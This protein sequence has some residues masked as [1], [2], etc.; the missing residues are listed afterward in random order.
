[1]LPRPLLAS[2]LEWIGLAALCAV[3]VFSGVT[4][5]TDPGAAHAEV[6]AFGLEGAALVVAATVMVQLAGSAAIL[7]G[8]GIVRASGALALLAFTV[9]A[10][11]IGHAFWHE[12]G[13]ARARDLNVFLE[14]IGLAGAF[15]L[16]AVRSLTHR[17]RATPPWR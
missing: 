9:A 2:T 4:K 7:F 1:M 17:E 6:R 8:R 10:T 3:F 12:T 11:Y 13:A 5:F 15:L 14:H 16:V